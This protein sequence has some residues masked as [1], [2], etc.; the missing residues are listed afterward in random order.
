MIIA[1]LSIVMK[2]VSPFA[3]C[4]TIS[5]MQCKF[6]EMHWVSVGGMEELFRLEQIGYTIDFHVWYHNY[7]RS[8]AYLTSATQSC[9]SSSGP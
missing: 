9:V 7:I 1:W 5:P 4:L 2:D 6:D 8:A 3:Y